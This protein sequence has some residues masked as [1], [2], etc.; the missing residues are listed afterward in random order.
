MKCLTNGWEKLVDVSFQ[1]VDV[2]FQLV[3]VSEK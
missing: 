1:L 2:S 3:D